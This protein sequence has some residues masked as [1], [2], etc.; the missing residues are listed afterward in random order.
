MSERKL[1]CI[2]GWPVAESLSPAIHNA[3]FAALG[4]DW[5]YVPLA[6]RPG[7]ISEGMNLLRQLGIEGANVTM[8]HKRAVVPMLDRLEADA[9][10]L[11]AVNTIVREGDAF[12]GHN[13]DGRGFLAAVADEA[14]F[15][16]AGKT[17]VVL[18]AG[19]A[20]RAVA[21]ALAQAGASVRVSARRAGQASEVAALTPGI[22]VAAWGESASTDLVVN[23]TPSREGLPLDSLGFAPGVLA[24]DLI[25]LPPMTEFVR[26]AREA[27]ARAFD[28]LGMLVHQAA[29]SFRLWTKLDPPLDVMAEAARAALSS[30]DAIDLR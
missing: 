22:D 28:G 26:F 21:V 10:A 9:A 23:A 3:A 12:V 6:V 13:T 2:I 24:V 4:L 14:A 18:G 11:D 16:P 19:G 15:E 8:P 1:A 20:A 29:L 25:Y 5:T 7:A 30:G 27:G 17:A